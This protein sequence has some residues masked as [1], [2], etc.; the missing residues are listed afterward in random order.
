MARAITRRPD[1]RASW[2]LRSGRSSGAFPGECGT[3]GFGR[4]KSP[5][6]TSEQ[7]APQW[8]GRAV[9]RCWPGSHVGE[10]ARSRHS[11]QEEVMRMSCGWT[12]FRA[13]VL[14]LGFVAMAAAS[15]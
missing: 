5:E 10:V 8:L 12:G 3:G 11:I 14:A 2:A 15:G 4:V 1:P 7:A 13:G 6:E 9:E